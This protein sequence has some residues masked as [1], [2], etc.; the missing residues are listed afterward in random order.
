MSGS[1]LLLVSGI[2]LYISAEQCYKCN[3]GVSVA[4]FGYALSNVGMYWVSK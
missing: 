2:Y 4:F 1:L 3:Y